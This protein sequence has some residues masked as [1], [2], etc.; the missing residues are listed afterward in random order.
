[1]PK[2]IQVEATQPQTSQP[3]ACK[4]KMDALTAS[5]D[6][7]SP[8]KR[9]RLDNEEKITTPWCT[10]ER[11]SSLSLAQAY[12]LIGGDVDVDVKNLF[13]H[14]PSG[15]N[16]GRH[17]YGAL[18]IL[19]SNAILCPCEH[20]FLNGLFRI[21]SLTAY[22]IKQIEQK[23]INGEISEDAFVSVTG[24]KKAM[25][26]G[27][28]KTSKKTEEIMTEEAKI[29]KEINSLPKAASISASTLPEKVVPSNR[30]SSGDTGDSL[31]TNNERGK[32]SPKKKTEGV[33]DAYAATDKNLDAANGTN[34]P[35][36]TGIYAGKWLLEHIFYSEMPIMTQMIK[37]FMTRSNTRP[38]MVT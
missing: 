18:T 32:K 20:H 2:E 6:A 4:N 26:I 8:K 1:M 31:S 19:F 12:E 15:E 38:R 5:I 28:A 29:S 36:G 10:K 9:R 17:V 35:R 24:L 27:E 13:G 14:I 21:I 11:L 25:E 34:K 37:C 7:P 3:A 16:R 23:I 22:L 30:N 33:V